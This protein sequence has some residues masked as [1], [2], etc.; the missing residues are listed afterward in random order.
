MRGL[1][2]RL[3]YTFVI[4][5]ALMHVFC[6]GLPL[7]L[8]AANVAALF[9]IAGA[10]AIHAPW[11]EQIEVYVLVISGAMLAI[12]GLIQYISNRIDCRTEGSCAHEPCDKK[13]HLSARIF[14]I[15]LALYSLNLLL[16]FFSHAH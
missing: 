3:A 2:Q 5:S 12:T 1:H 13:K 11:F 10:G 4:S 6:C 14:Q 7:M 16:Y 15:A 8:T 9:G